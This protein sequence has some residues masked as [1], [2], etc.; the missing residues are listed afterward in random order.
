LGAKGSPTK[1]RD[2]L[3]KTT[4]SPI[5][6]LRGQQGAN[7]EDQEG[8]GREPNSEGTIGTPLQSILGKGKTHLGTG[9]KKRK[10]CLA[11]S[12]E[13]SLGEG[14]VRT[15]KLLRLTGKKSKRGLRRAQGPRR[16]K[17]YG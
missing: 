7:G 2:G 1:I 8:R 5:W 15:K 13:M 6:F 12:K 14:K 10:L 9:K 3:P 17:E 16:K 11:A 4:R